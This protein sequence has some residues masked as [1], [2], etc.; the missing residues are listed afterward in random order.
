MTPIMRDIGSL[1]NIYKVCENVTLSTGKVN[2]KD[3]YHEIT[4]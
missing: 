3:I 4:L 1:S 2:N